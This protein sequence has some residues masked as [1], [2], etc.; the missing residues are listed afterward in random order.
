M[1][2][3]RPMSFEPWFGSVRLAFEM[4]ENVAVTATAAIDPPIA[5]T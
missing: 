2:N 1:P 5:S 3:L 4:C